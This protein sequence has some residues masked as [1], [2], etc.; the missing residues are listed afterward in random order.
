MLCGSACSSWASIEV[1][2]SSW[3][4]VWL[5]QV[6]IWFTNARKRFWVPLRQQLGIEVRVWKSGPRLAHPMPLAFQ[7]T[8]STSPTLRHG[9]LG[10]WLVP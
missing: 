10:R 6:S 7:V 2:R 4:L 3:S 1:C 8:T 9:G 5:S